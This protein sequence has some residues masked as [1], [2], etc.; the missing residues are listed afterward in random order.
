MGKTELARVLA[1]EFFGSEKQLIKIDMSEF[2]ERHTAARLVGAPAGYI[3]YDDN[4][5]LT[6]KVRAIPTALSCSTKLRKPIQTY[7]ICFADS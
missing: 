6:E 4:G 2:G 5:E 3:G 1:R 7:S